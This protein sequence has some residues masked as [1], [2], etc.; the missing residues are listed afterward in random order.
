MQMEVDQKENEI[1]VAPKILPMVDLEGKIVVEDTLHTQRK[2]SAQIVEAGGDY[3]W[4]LKENQSTLRQAI[5]RFFE[6]EVQ[7]PGFGL[8]VTDLRKTSQVNQGHGRT[9]RRTLTATRVFAGELDWPKA[10]QVFKLERRFRHHRSGRVNQETV[11][12]ITSL[13][14]QQADAAQLLPIHRGY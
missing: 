2:V 1:A 6:P 3:C 11:F 10:R 13:S 5:E 14:P 4:T 12:G 8:A 7:T 9:E